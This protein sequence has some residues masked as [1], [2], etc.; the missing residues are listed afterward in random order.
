VRG[1][2]SLDDAI[3]GLQR[4]ARDRTAFVYAAAYEKADDGSAYIQDE[5]F[6]VAQTQPMSSASQRAVAMSG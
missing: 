1:Y 4:V 6:G 5:E 2:R 3:D